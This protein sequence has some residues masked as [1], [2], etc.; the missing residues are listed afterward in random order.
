MSVADVRARG[1]RRHRAARSTSSS[2][3]WWRSLDAT[4]PSAGSSSRSAWCSSSRL[5]PTPTSSTARGWSGDLPGHPSARRAH[6]R[7]VDP[8]V[9]ARRPDP[10]AHPDRAVPVAAVALGG[11]GAVGGR[12]GCLPAGD[13]VREDA[14]PAVPALAEPDGGRRD[15]AVGG[16]AGHRLRLHDRARADRQRDLVAAAVPPGR[17]RR[18]PTAALAGVR[19][20]TPPAVRGRGL[21]QL[22][23]RRRAGHGH[24]HRRLHHPGAD[25]RRALG[26]A[27]PALRRRADRRGHRHLGAAHDDRGGDLRVHGLARRPCGRERTGVARHWPPRSAP[28][29]RPAWPSRC[30]GRCRTRWTGVSTGG[31][32]TRAG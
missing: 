17:R 12:A 15:P 23:Q 31:R 9:H 28:W 3:R 21:R 16:P 13:P 8:L 11:P 20:R 22:A 29:P 1:R 25:R 2:G 14:R 19:R 30:A 5:R 6:G 7:V 32:T 26:A 10:P 4:T 18:A 24:R 27:L